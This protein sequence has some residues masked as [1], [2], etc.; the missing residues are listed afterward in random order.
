MRNWMLAAALP[1]LLPATAPAQARDQRAAQ[2]PRELRIEYVQDSLPN[3]LQVIYHVDRSTP[4]AAVVVWYDVGSKH[5]EPG[6]TGFAHLFEHM[7]FKGSRNVPDGQHFG[8]LEQAGGRAGQDINGTTS[9][10]RTNYFQQVPSNQL[11]LALWLEADRM[12]TLLDAVDQEKLDNQREV[13]KNERRQGVDNQPYGTWWEEMHAKAYP[14]GH[15]YH[16]S[17]IGSMEDLSA[18]TLEDVKNFF[19]TYYAPNNAVLVIAGDIDVDRTREQVRKHFGWIPRGPA[20]PPLRSTDLPALIGEERRGVVDDALAPAPAVFVGFRVPP[21]RA[22][23][24]PAVQLLAQVIASGRSSRLYESLV[25]QQ[26]I[27]TSVFGFNSGKVDG[28]DLIIFGAYGRPTTDPDSLERALIAELDRAM[29]GFQAEELERAKVAVR[30]S[31]VNALQ[32][33]GGFGGR[34]DRLAEAKTYFDDPDY[35]NRRLAQLQAVTLSQ[36]NAL[37]RER[38]VPRNRVTLVYV[39]ARQQ[40]A[41]VVP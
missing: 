15:P 38:L 23:N 8:L 35:V 4:V 6:R 33:L 24:S 29:E 32:T 28:A 27:A 5:E 2:Q 26:Q 20:P 1:M 17:V 30:F 7:M 39:P 36:V 40:A 16:H 21:L 37:A 12:G 22:E 18:A 11:E 41:E 34:A 13:V 25:R 9:N 10:D 3:G 14:E 31:N 19:R